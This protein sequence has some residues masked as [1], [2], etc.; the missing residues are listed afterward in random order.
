MKMKIT[1]CIISIVL[2]ILSYLAGYDTCKEHYSKYY[3]A[4]EE[5]LDSI[6]EDYFLDVIMEKDEY[7]DYLTAKESL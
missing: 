4:T 6:D 7:Q 5:L 1:I 2:V 3:N